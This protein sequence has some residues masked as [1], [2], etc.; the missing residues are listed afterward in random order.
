MERIAF[1]GPMCSGKTYMA[2]YLVDN[3][4]FLKIGFADKLKEVARDLF[5]I[6]PNDKNDR[7]R[8]LLQEF[9]DD[10]KKWGGEDI[11]VKHFLDKISD[12]YFLPLVCDDL[13]YTFE[14]DALREEGFKII[15]VNAYE[16]F[17]QERI[18]KLYPDT[19]LEAQQHRSETDSK[20]IEPDYTIWSN[21]PSDTKQ[22]DE[23]LNG[24][25]RS[26][27]SIRR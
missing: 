19:S 15:S 12:N 20:L 18:F 9:S 25:K 1:Y 21:N 3:Y 24:T 2:K 27:I 8:R 16:N 14:A 17:R 7:N 11:F 5:W 6:N 4:G 22:L 23:L 26:K 13:R 10:I